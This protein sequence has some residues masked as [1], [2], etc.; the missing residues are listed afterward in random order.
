MAAETTGSMSVVLEVY[1]ARAIVLK[2]SAYLN[3]KAVE[4]F[5]ADA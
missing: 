4:T 3:V 2:G 5:H 1:W